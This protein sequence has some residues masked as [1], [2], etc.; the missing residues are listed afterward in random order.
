MVEPWEHDGLVET[1]LKVLLPVLAKTARHQFKEHIE[2]GAHTQ[3][4]SEDDQTRKRTQAV[5]KH[6]KFAESAFGFLDN[7]MKTKP[8][9]STL[10]AESYIC[11]TYNKTSEWLETKSYY[12]QNKLFAESRADASRLK[13]QFKI[14]HEAILTERTLQVQKKIQEEEQRE[15]KRIKQMEE[16]TSQI[17]H[18]GLWQNQQ[19]V[20]K[21]LEE[22]DNKSEKIEALKS[23]LRFRQKVFK[24]NPSQ[25]H[26]FNFT[27]KTDTSKRIAL[28]VEELRIN[29]NTL[30]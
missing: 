5:P 27:K 7:L 30:I 11:F 18:Y 2:E 1:I 4:D 14:R 25:K 15:K 20:T 19:E 3:M 8:N 26:L 9:L 28:T 16:Y 13:Q 21:H 6:N 12:E 24:Q 29:L 22:L 23:Q 17:I 10:S